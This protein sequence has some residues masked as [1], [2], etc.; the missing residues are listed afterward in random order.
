[1]DTR[2]LTEIGK[3]ARQETEDFVNHYLHD[4]TKRWPLVR[5]FARAAED[6]AQA[7]EA[8]SRDRIR[9]LEARQMAL[10]CGTESK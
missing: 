1:M 10:V 8:R 6:V 7:Q 9:I 4:Q 3:K 5:C 2:E